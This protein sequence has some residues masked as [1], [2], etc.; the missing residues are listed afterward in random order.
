MGNQGKKATENP[1]TLNHVSQSATSDPARSSWT[2]HHLTG[3]ALTQ[4]G[5]CFCIC[6]LNLHKNV[7]NA[8]EMSQKYKFDTFIERELFLSM[9]SKPEHYSEYEQIQWMKC[10]PRSCDELERYWLRF[11]P[12]HKAQYLL[13]TRTL[14]VN[15]DTYRLVRQRWKHNLLLYFVQD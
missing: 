12:P 4:F 2:P 13:R 15:G 14:C 1:I 11:S 3:D 7:W 9:H 10:W 6:R 5:C 8:N